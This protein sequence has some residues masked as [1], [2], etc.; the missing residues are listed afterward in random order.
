MANENYEYIKCAY[1]LIINYEGDKFKAINSFKEK[2]KVSNDEA[3]H[4]VNLAYN[5]VQNGETLEKYK[6][7]L[8]IASNDKKED[9]NKLSS[10]SNQGPEKKKKSNKKLLIFLL[11]VIGALLFFSFKSPS[12]FLNSDDSFEDCYDLKPVE[13]DFFSELRE[14]NLDKDLKKAGIKRIKAIK[15]DT[16][17]YSAGPSVSFHILDENNDEFIGMTFEE[18]DGWKLYSL[19]KELKDS[20]HCYLGCDEDED[21]YD[22]KTDK[23]IK[24]GKKSKNKEKHKEYILGNDEESCTLWNGK[25]YCY[26]IPSGTYSVSRKKIN[27]H[28]IDVSYVWIDYD[29]VDF[30]EDNGYEEHKNKDKYEF[31]SDGDSFVIDIDED[32]HVDLTTY[33]YIY[34]FEEY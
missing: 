3:I 6:P 22:C 11:I 34:T 9:E 4:Y 21:L 24:K 17:L 28:A 29:E 33:D 13:P 27:D 19:S 7:K 20:S 25:D 23:L 31:T 16:D 10:L 30:V 26:K 5:L 32:T 8:N 18:D 2:F 15:L 14:Y 1:D 12:R